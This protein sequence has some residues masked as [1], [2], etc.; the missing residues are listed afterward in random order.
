MPP[1]SFA[2]GFEVQGPMVGAMTAMTNATNDANAAIG[3]FAVAASEVSK[4]RNRISAETLAA[5][6]SWTAIDTGRT[7]KINDARQKRKDFEDAIRAST[8]V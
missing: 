3:K 8:T 6:D 5:A 4:A 1:T 7:G 2:E